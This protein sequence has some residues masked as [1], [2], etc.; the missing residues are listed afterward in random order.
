MPDITMCKGVNKYNMICPRMMMCYRYRA[1]PNP[2]YQSY[3]I[4]APLT[5]KNECTFFDDYT[6]W[7]K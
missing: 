2:F 5:K 4:N 7:R 3:F 1:H 6:K